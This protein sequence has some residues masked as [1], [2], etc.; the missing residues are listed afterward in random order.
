MH[1]LKSILNFFYEM[2]LSKKDNFYKTSEKTYQLMRYLYKF[3]DGLFLYFISKYLNKKSK[4][5]SYFKNSFKFLEKIENDEKHFLI[6]EISNMRISNSII[7]GEKI[8]FV[9]KELKEIDYSYYKNKNLMRLDIQSEDLLKNKRIAKIA[10]NEKW[11]K[12]VE[13]ILGCEPK[14]LGVDAWYTLPAPEKFKTYDDVGKLVS[15]QM[16]HRDCDNLRDIKI[17]I[18]LTDVKDENEGPFELVENTNSFNFFN[19]FKYEMG[20]IGLRINDDYIKKKYNGYIKSIYG[21]EG[22]CY[23]IDTRA[24]HRGK[25]IIKENHYRLMLQLLFSNNSFGKIRNNPKLKSNWESYQIWREFADRKN[26]LNCLF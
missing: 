7:R 23:L 17:M 13:D 22:D 5:P 25:T 14:L 12:I 18:Y 24:I 10:T 6:D 11:I 2:T 16:W 19:P 20:S 8:K 9:D 15:S 3:S 21:N 1:R 4:P 26:N